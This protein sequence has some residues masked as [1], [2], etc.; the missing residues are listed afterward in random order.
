[1]IYNLSDMKKNILLK[2]II[3]LFSASL[4]ILFSGCSPDKTEPVITPPS[5]T[6]QQQPSSD[7]PTFSEPD[8]PPATTESSVPTAVDIFKPSP[9]SAITIDNDHDFIVDDLEYELISRFAPIVKFHSDEQYLLADI[10][11]YLERVRLRFDISFG[12][13]AQ[14]LDHGEITM[15]NLV[16]QNHKAQSSG[17][18][19]ECTNFFLEQTDSKGDD[20][21]DTYRKTTRQGSPQN[22][23]VCYAHVRVA[24][25]GY[26]MF[27]IQYI[28][29][30][31]YNGDLLLS[32]A[33][34][35]HEADFEHI[36]VRVRKYLQTIEKI[37]YAAHDNEG[38][39]YDT[40]SSMGMNDGYQLYNGRPLVYSALDS[41]A[42]YPWA[43]IWDRNNLPDDVTD[44][45]GITWDSL[46]KVINLGEKEHPLDDCAWIQYSGR[47]GELGDTNFTRGPF[48]PAYQG[49]WN[50]D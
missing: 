34:S 19:S 36:T 48:S 25:G 3:F 37:Y 18:S 7:I 24:D 23:W 17:L 1:M 49:W 43:A 5:G 13:D 27:D 47:F 38:K 26:E 15:D 33:E 28:F 39:W 40:Q 4:I 44:A 6:E 30:Y 9:S 45:S 12:F 2:R 20:E 21:L 32:E 29:F 42:S 50:G 31:A 16:S 14:L 22:D 11:W 35:A 8:I 10:P 41:H 46:D